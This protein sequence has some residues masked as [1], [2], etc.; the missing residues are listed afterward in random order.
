MLAP[1]SMIPFCAPAYC[2]STVHLILGPHLPV[3]PLILCILSFLHFCIHT[4]LFVI[5]HTGTPSVAFDTS[6]SPP[7]LNK[8]VNIIRE[9]LSTPIAGPT[10]PANRLPFRLPSAYLPVLFSSLTPP[11]SSSP[12]LYSIYRRFRRRPL[13][14]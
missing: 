11:S 12:H 8:A 9:I 14:I 3:L 2:T 4:C 13:S 6:T 1:F 5:Y 10:A 7:P